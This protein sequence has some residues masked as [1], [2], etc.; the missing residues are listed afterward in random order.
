MAM[1]EHYGSEHASVIFVPAAAV[2][3]DR[4]WQVRHPILSKSSEPFLARGV[5]ASCLSARGS[6]CRAHEAGEAIDI[7]RT[8]GS[9]WLFGSERITELCH[10]VGKSRF[11]IPPFH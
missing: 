2:V 1:Q 5:S 3:N 11:V 7:G 10:L 6:F 4:T 8:S 9:G